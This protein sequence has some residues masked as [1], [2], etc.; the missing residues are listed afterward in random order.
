MTSTATARHSQ[1]DDYYHTN[2][3]KHTRPGKAGVPG[4]WHSGGMADTRLEA[5][6]RSQLGAIKCRVCHFHGGFYG[7]CWSEEGEDEMKLEKGR[8]T[9]EEALM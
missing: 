2:N 1:R 7:L 4:Q 9:E 6:E 8:W 3:V 5:K